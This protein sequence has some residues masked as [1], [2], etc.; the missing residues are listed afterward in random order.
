M[1]AASEEGPKDVPGSL[2]GMPSLKLTLPMDPAV[3]PDAEACFRGT[4]S[5]Q[6]VLG[7]GSLRA[8]PTEPR[9]R[10]A[11]QTYFR[12]IAALKWGP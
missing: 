1:T 8:G 9:R 3:Q 7:K 4:L 12:W 6:G 11:R 5:V 2:P 10:R